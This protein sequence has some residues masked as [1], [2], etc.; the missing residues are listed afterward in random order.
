MARYIGPKDKISRNE[1]MDIYSSG[2]KYLGHHKPNSKKKLSQYG[3]QLRSKQRAKYFY[4]VLE[5]QFR[6][7]V[8]LA[9]KSKAKSG[10]ALVALLEKR[11]DNVIYRLGWAPNRPAARQLVNHGHVLV[12]Q[13][14][15]S[16]PSYQVKPND[17]IT[18]TEKGWNIPS[19]KD[20]IE[21]KKPEKA[22][23]LEITNNKA[24]MI[25][26]PEL[27]D[28]KEPINVIDIIEFYSR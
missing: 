27:T 3:K 19:T 17:E 6:N 28:L 22:E 1:G 8:M 18:L 4:G 11:L 9:N 2:D 16:I 23:W 25:R 5:K 14:I 20:T 7:Y 13:K 24:K 12:N 15:L 21:N 26:E 10:N